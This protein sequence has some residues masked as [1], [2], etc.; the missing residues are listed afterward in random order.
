MD[1][2]LLLHMV[3]TLLLTEDVLLLLVPPLT[4][5]PPTSMSNLVQF[6]LNG[7]L[8]QYLTL[9]VLPPH[10]DT[11]VPPPHPIILVLPLHLNALVPPPHPVILVL[12]LH[13]NILVPPPQPIVHPHR[14]MALHPIM[15]ILPPQP[16]IHPYTRKED[17]D[18]EL[19]VSTSKKGKSA[20]KKAKV[21]AKAVGKRKHAME[22]DD[23][24]LS[25]PARHPKWQVR[26]WK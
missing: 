20:G 21:T 7:L 2:L 22:S 1:V 15:L 10:L 16:I 14:K 6:H 17:E 12:P 18:E 3:G 11:L 19:K 5:I 26:R 8:P 9:L 13:L 24:Q 25:E 23:E 4:L